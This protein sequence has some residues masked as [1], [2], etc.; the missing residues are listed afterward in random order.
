MEDL[1]KSFGAMS[2]LEQA[3]Y[4]GGGKEYIFDSSSKA[5]V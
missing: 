4:I 2:E 1:K 3:L 5:K